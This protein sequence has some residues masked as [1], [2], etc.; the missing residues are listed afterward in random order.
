MVKVTKKYIENKKK[1]DIKEKNV[2]ISFN[3]KCAS[4]STKREY[5]GMKNESKEVSSKSISCN[6]C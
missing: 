6:T 4:F 5:G 3:T 2:I 1:I